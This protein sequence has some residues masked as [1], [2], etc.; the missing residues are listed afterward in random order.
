MRIWFGRDGSRLKCQVDTE[1]KVPASIISFEL[2]FCSELWA[3]LLTQY[4]NKALQDEWERAHQEAYEAGYRAGKGKKRKQIFFARG[5]TYPN[6]W[7]RG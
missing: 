7:G 4:L 5:P 1:R 6:Y 2:E 3:D